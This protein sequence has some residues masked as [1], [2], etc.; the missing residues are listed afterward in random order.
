MNQ[1]SSL[2][3]RAPSNRL[4]SAIVV[5]FVVLFEIRYQVAASTWT[6]R[7]LVLIVAR[8]RFHR[9]V[10]GLLGTSSY[11]HDTPGNCLRTELLHELQ[12]TSDMKLVGFHSRWS[13]PRRHEFRYQ[14]NKPPKGCGT[15]R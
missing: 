10:P 8:L 1:I 13:K 9:P 2:S 3:L 15:T 6:R 14:L 11:Q 4:V 5:N 12:H 7:G